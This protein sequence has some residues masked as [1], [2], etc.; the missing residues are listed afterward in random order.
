MA[1]IDPFYSVNESTKP[2]DNRRHH[3]N[4]QCPP[5]RDIP[6]SERKQGTGGYKL[7]E[8]CADLS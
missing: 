2:A 6:T 4:D 1:K 7:C 8:H 5:G 3:N